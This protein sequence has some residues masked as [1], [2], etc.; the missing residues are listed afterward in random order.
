MASQE[1]ARLF[2]DDPGPVLFE[3][4]LESKFAPALRHLVLTVM[5]DK[6]PAIRSSL[7]ES[8]AERQEELRDVL[9]VIDIL[10][11]ED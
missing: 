1:T 10:H 4:L 9:N 6:G 5:E 7:Q 2:D 3:E 11:P 8:S